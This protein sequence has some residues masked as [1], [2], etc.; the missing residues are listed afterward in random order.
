MGFAAMKSKGQVSIEFMLIILI[1]L[2]YIQFIQA[3]A[4]GPATASTE[5]TVRLGQAKLAAQKLANSINEIAASSGEGKKTIHLF[6]PKYS[7]L[8]CDSSKVYFTAALESYYYNPTN[9]DPPPHPD[10]GDSD[11]FGGRELFKC[12]G[13]VALVEGV[14]F[15]GG[16]CMHPRDAA[17]N[18]ISVT[19]EIR[20]TP[21]GD[22]SIQ[23]V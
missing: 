12:S 16:D 11:V 17:D 22:I 18:P 23:S 19:V 14:S 8:R 10:C 1:A 15:L 7:S 2:I 3:T 6:I 5:D 13:D 21:A 9:P 20:K 4:L